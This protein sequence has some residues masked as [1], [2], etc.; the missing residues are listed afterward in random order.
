[1]LKIQEPVFIET[2]I[3]EPPIE[4]FDISVLVRL[5]GLDET[6][7]HLVSMGLCEHGTPAEFLAVVRSNDLGQPSLIAKAIK[8]TCQMMSANGPFRH[9][10]YRLV[11]GVIND[12]EALEGPAIGGAVEGEIHGPDLVGCLRSHRRL[13]IGDGLLLAPTAPHLK[14]AWGPFNGAFQ[15][16]P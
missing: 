1:M 12:G 6:L 15:A 14:P 8:D 5:S 11:G 13:A 2:L 7:S 16:T 10:R 9:D 4:G 3:P